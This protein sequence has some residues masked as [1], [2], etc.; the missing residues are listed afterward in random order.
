VGWAHWTFGLMAQLTLV[1]AVA[2]QSAAVEQS[3]VAAESTLALTRFNDN[4]DGTVTDVESKLMWMRCPSGQRWFNAGCTGQ[5]ATYNWG[6]ALRQASQVSSSGEAFFNDW[7]VPALRDLA[8]ITDRGCK[9]PRTNLV[10]FPGTPPTAFW[11]S[12][13]RPG[14]K[15]E[16]LAFALSFG[17]EG[18]MAARKDER[19]YVRFVRNAM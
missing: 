11:T 18:V 17:E 3:C 10:L 6:D 13:L 2:A 16:E 7:R 8:T 19:F 4:G 14:G 5:A 15:P 12:T 9:N 1:G